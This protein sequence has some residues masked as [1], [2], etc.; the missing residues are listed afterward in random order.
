MY[1]KKST[2]WFKHK[3]F[4][5][6]DLLSVFLALVA[7]NFVRNGKFFN[8]YQDEIYRDAGI[9]IILIDLCML[10]LF[11]VY[12]GVLRRGYYQ[13]F[14]TVLKQMF[15]LELCSGLYL[16]SADYDHVFSRIVL[17][18]MGIFYS[19]IT[20]LTRILWKK[21][22]KTRM[23]ENGSVS[24]YII[25]TARRAAEVTS[26]IQKNNYNQYHI[27]GIVLADENF[28][29]REILGIPVVSDVKNAAEYICQQWVD[30]VLIDLDKD[31][32]QQQE[33]VKKLLEMGI[34]VHLNLEGPQMMP[35]QKVFTEKVGKYEVLTMTVNYI[36]DMQAILKRLMDIVGGLTGC[37]CTGILC[38]FVAPA[39]YFSSPGPVFFSQIRIGQNGKPFK[40]YKFRSMYLDAEKRKSELLD[41]NKVKDGRM[42]KLDFD[43]RVIG[44]K[45]LPDGTKK[46]GIGEFIRRTSI[47]EFSQFWNVLNGSMSL[48]GTRPILPD[49]LSAYELHHRM[50]IAVKPG[51]TGMW[52]ISGRND[53]TDFEEVVRLDTKYI[54]DWSLGLDIRIL[55]RTVGVVLKR[56]GAM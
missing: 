46:T 14:C 36:T 25:T 43:P 34:V 53:I 17:Y 49:E 50:R 12:K 4:I 13:E 41:Q 45:I 21:Y 54:T 44:N 11:E 56:N 35:G 30:E 48:V 40:M 32:P 31:T 33:L 6:L 28:S 47:D 23:T 18:L 5:L 39:I 2:G 52:Q 24:L 3:D 27:S 42:F 19:V 1:K 22:L 20:Y 16:F 8:L 51:I 9:F 7:A 29:E 55:I 15:L 37:I 26:G 38:I 10:I